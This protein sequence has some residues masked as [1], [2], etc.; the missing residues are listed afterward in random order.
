VPDIRIG[1]GGK[2]LPGA[3][4]I[5][6]LAPPSRRSRDV[7]CYFDNDMKV[8]APFDALRLIEKLGS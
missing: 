6:S 2:E 1:T 4:K 3:K 5:A 7:Y 8:K